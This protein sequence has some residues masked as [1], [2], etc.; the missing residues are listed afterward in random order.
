MPKHFFANKGRDVRCVRCSLKASEGLLYPMAKFFIFIHKPTVVIKFSDI[1]TIK[2]DR[3][4]AGQ[5]STRR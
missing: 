5:S 3:L 1:E 2:F 4:E